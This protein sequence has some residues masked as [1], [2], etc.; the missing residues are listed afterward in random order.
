MTVTDKILLEWS[1]RCHDGIVDMN[2][3][4]KLAILK[5]VLISEGIDEDIVDAILN[6]PKDDP[7][8]EEK[9]RKVLNYLTGSDDEKDKEI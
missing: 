7:S 8:S 2:N 5:E 3:P 4:K 6:L 9:K 1:Y